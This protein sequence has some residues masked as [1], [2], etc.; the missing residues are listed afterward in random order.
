MQPEVIASDVS[1]GRLGLRPETPEDD[2]F[3]LA[4][5]ASTRAAEMELTNWTADQRREFLRSQ[6]QL[7]RMHYRRYYTHAAFDVITLNDVPIGRMYV[8]S[9]SDEIRLMEI[10]IDPAFQGRGIG[11]QLVRSVLA[12][13]ERVGKTVTLHVEPFNPAFRLYQRLGFT[14]VEERGLNFLLERRPQVGR[15]A[16]TIS[17][18]ASR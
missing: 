16:A 10:S 15:A 13:A 12:E 2:D 8:H 18:T 17:P 6:F 14:I 11:T 7:Q 5:Y 4:L 9:G 3:L 1:I